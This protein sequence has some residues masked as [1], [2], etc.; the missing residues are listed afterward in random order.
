MM[1]R[2]WRHGKARIEDRWMDEHMYLTEGRTA[3]FLGGFADHSLIDLTE[4]TEKHNRYASREA[5]ELL[6]ERFK[7]LPSGTDLTGQRT[8]RQAKAKRFVKKSIYDRCPHEIS[9]F[10]YLI[11]RYIFR[12]GFLDGKEGLIYH[13][14]Q[15]FWYRFLVGAKLRELEAAM[16]RASSEDEIRAAITRLT[17]MSLTGD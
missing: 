9:S 13:L 5:L 10:A 2:I 16:R 4:F 14:L 7:L 17:R 3:N 8:A 15:G 6:N 12:L 1:L 11:Y